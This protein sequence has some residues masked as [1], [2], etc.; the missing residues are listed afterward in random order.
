MNL[1]CYHLIEQTTVYVNYMVNIKLMSIII[2][3][4]KQ[5]FE[6]STD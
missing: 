4:A 5:V 6:L 2:L 3:L 1:S